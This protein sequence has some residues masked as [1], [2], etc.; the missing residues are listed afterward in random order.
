MNRRI[1]IVFAV[2]AAGVFAS[3]VLAQPPVADNTATHTFAA[4]RFYSEVRHILRRHYPQATSHVLNNDVHF[5]H[6]TRLF[7][8]HEPTKTGRWQDPWPER[9]PRQGGIYCEIKY[10][11]GKYMG[12]AATPQ[13][14]NKRY[15]TL[16][17]L[18][19]SSTKLNAHL[20]VHLKYPSTGKMP[21]GFL[22]QMVDVINNF[23]KY[24]IAKAPQ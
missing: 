14:F 17:L 12:A 4:N 11:P 2:A 21:A 15:F 6:N 13:S 10:Q 16:M 22:A 23:E 3:P 24:A 18:A 8:L 1:A 9:G 7:I 5:E 20:F 19:P